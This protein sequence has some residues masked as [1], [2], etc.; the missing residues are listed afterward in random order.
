MT[1]RIDDA[2]RWLD[3]RFGALALYRWL[4]GGAWTFYPNGPT[5]LDL[6]KRLR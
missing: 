3:E 5:R 1:A 2:R 6:L 4:A